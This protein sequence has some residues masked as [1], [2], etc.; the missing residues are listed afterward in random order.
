VVLERNHSAL[1]FTPFNTRIMKGAIL[2]DI[3]GSRFEG[4]SAVA[5]KLQMKLASAG[6]IAGRI[7]PPNKTTDFTLLTPECHFT[8]DTVLTVA[9][10]DAILH[11]KDYGETIKDYALRYPDAGYGGTFRKWMRDELEEEYRSWGN[12]SAMRVSPVGWLFNDLETV[13]AQAK[14]SAVPTHGHPEGVK[15]AQAIAAAIFLARRGGGKEDI[16]RYITD[17][18]GYNLRRTIEEI[19]PEYVFDVSCQGSVPEAIIAFLDS[20]NLVDG[21]RLAVSL[22]GDTDTQ[23]AMAGCIGEAFYGPVAPALEEVMNAFLPNDLIGVIG[24]F[25]RT[26]QVG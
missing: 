18:F 8:D 20:K 6:K 9:V 10:A 4:K 24:A 11:Q 23:A 15:G 7:L 22:G 5:G 16:R 26:L 13:L 1:V 12:G 25:D 3:V 21:I 19:R 17:T 2:G 14:A